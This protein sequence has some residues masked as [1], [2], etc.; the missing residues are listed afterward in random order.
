MSERQPPKSCTVCT[1]GYCAPNRCYCGHEECTAF[2]SY[3]PRDRIKAAPIANAAQHAKS[4]NTR[5][6]DTWLDK[7]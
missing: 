6:E 4:W 5:D 1:S 2:H 3:I 7:L